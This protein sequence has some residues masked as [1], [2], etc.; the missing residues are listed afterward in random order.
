MTAEL[1][2]RKRAEWKLPPKEPDHQGPY[3][4]LKLT[5]AS[6]VSDKSSFTSPATRSF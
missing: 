4:L 2:E 6:R 3:C 5:V 1:R